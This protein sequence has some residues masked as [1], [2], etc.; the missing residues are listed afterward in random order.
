[1]APK[2]KS[3]LPK[4]GSHAEFHRKHGECWLCRFLGRQQTTLT[5]LH[6]IAGRGNRHEVCA[7]YAA[8][9][10]GCHKAVQSLKDS[11][12]VCLVLKWQF[13]P[14]NYCAA[15]IC[16][17]RGCAETWITNADVDQCGRIMSMMREVT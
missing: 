4:Y 16:D 8:L 5:E 3:G 12:M 10:R 11:E 6:H 9:C 2:R 17:L 1:M 7:N 14:D 13:D 15:I